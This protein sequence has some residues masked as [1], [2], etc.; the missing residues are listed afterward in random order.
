[1]HD[2]HVYM[3]E[4]KSCLGDWNNDSSNVMM[5]MRQ[6]AWHVYNMCIF[7]WTNVGDITWLGIKAS[8][9]GFEFNNLQNMKKVSLMDSHP[10]VGQACTTPLYA[11]IL[12]FEFEN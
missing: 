2:M 3:E 11:Y 4:I 6:I 1:M 8:Q 7:N 5:S 9:Y 12:I 10:L